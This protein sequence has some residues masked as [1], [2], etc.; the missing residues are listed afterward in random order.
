MKLIVCINMKKFI[1]EKIEVPKG[2]ANADL[3][4]R[5]Y[6]LGLHPGLEV[7]IVSKISFNSVTVIQ[8]GSTRLALNEEEFACLHGR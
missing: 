3:I 2:A 8:Y 6:D 1:L 7:E 5:L 4:K